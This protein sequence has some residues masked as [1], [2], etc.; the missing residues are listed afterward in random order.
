MK[1][2]MSAEPFEQWA[3]VE[4]FGHARIAGRVTEEQIGGASFIRVDVPALQIRRDGGDLTVPIVIEEREAFTR[5]F[6]PAAI[7]SITPTSEEVARLAAAE[8][9]SEPISV[10]IPSLRRMLGVRAGTPPELNEDPDDDPDLGE[11][12]PGAEQR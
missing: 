9:R 4:L 12:D 2:N 1:G 11:A 6:G 5:L 10:Y 7:Y 8:F 3:I